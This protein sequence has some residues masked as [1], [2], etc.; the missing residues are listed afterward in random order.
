[1]E[2]R[3]LPGSPGFSGTAAGSLRS[4]AN[5]GSENCVARKIPASAPSNAAE[6]AREEETFRWKFQFITKA[7]SLRG[8]GSLHFTAPDLPQ[9]GGAAQPYVAA[10]V[11]ALQFLKHLN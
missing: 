7:S 3:G 8:G 9:S 1:M 6:R 5:A 10:W 4:E 2:V 11:T